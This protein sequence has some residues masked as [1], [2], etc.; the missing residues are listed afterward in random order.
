MIVGQ[1]FTDE[2]LGFAF[3]KGDEKTRKLFNEGLAK[4]KGSGKL[5]EIAA[6]WLK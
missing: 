6:K 1:P 4:V 3:K 5:D 2:W